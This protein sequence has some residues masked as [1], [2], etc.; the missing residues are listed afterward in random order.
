M[1]S[2]EQEHCLRGDKTPEVDYSE[3]PFLLSSC[4]GDGVQPAGLPKAPPVPAGTCPRTYL[5]E[6]GTQSGWRGRGRLSKNTN[7]TKIKKE[8]GKIKKKGSQSRNS[9]TLQSRGKVSACNKAFTPL[10]LSFTH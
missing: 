1:L 10:L 5:H 9:V 8:K 6:M 4:L 2:T 3:P 7:K